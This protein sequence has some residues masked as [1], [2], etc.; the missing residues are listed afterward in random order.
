MLP[1]S[2]PTGPSSSERSGGHPRRARTSRCS[3]G[4]RPHLGTTSTRRWRRRRSAPR[5]QRTWFRMPVCDLGNR[6]TTVHHDGTLT[7]RGADETNTTKFCQIRILRESRLGAMDSRA[8]EPPARGSLRQRRSTTRP[9]V[10]RWSGAA[11]RCPETPITA[12]GASSRCAWLY[13][14]DMHARETSKGG[15]ATRIWASSLPI[16]STHHYGTENIPKSVAT[17]TRMA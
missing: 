16:S 11:R 15:L 14:R 17:Q 4:R 13:F 1:L 7:P 2:P 6:A 5:A 3:P 9:S 12:S 8:R 10:T